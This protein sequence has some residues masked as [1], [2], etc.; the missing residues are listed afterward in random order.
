[1]SAT[2]LLGG[3]EMKDYEVVVLCGAISSEREVSLRSGANVAKLLSASVPTR[4]IAL[5]KNELP[6]SI[7]PEKSVIFPLFHGEFGEDGQAQKLLEEAGFEYVGSDSK[8]AALTMDKSRTKEVVSAAGLPVFP[9]RFYSFDALKDANV[10]QLKE[11]WSSSAVFLKPNNRGSSVHCHI[12]HSS[13][14]LKSLHFQLPQWDWLIEPF[15]PGRDLTQGVLQGKALGILEVLHQ[16]EFLTY[17][18]KYT[19]G[20]AK[21]ICPAPLSEDIARKVSEFSERAFQA[22]GSRDWAR[23]DFIL[24]P[25][26]NIKFL[27]VN[28]IPGFTATSFYPDCAKAVGI[29]PEELCM[30]VLQPTLERFRK[31]FL[32]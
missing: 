7:S 13:E 5:D 21:H 1:M 20:L 15:F 3:Y 24:L 28:S 2:H 4:L 8:S 12:L 9:Q 19:Q 32:S 31:R 17:D 26:G 30:R 27:E 10:E 25:D 29:S 6:V 14:E 11:V 18:E 22:C 16:N 23:C